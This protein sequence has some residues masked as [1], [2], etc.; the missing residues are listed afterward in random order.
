[1]YCQKWKATDIDVEYLASE[2]LTGSMTGAEIVGAC[3]AATMDAIRDA[4]TRDDLSKRETID[5][6]QEYLEG[7]LKT[8]KPL[9]S[10]PEVLDDFLRFERN[11]RSF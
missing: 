11:R 1:M 7:R 3:R 4:H 2:S 8:T 5:V 9:L 10:S 6:K